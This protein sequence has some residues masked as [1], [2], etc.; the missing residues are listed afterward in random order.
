MNRKLL[1]VAAA[2][3][4]AAVLIVIIIVSAG[5]LRSS[6]P[7]KRGVDSPAGIVAAAQDAEAKGNIQ[8][9]RSRYQRLVSEF[10]NSKDVMNWQ[11]KAEDLNIK[12]LFSPLVTVKSILY[13]IKPGDTL[14]KIAKNFR[15]TPEL[16]MKSNGLTDDKILP[17][18]KIKVWTVPFNIVVDKSQ[19][20]LILKS[21]DEIVKSYIVSTG[22]NN[23]TPTGTFKVINKLANPTWFKAGAV[24]DPGSPENILGTR[25]LG[26]NVPGYGIHGTTDPQSLGKQATQ[27][28]VRMANPEVEELYVIVPEGT[29]V[30]IID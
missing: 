10:P 17:G 24:V 28:C 21:E 8:E 12:L 25:W 14:I 13:E 1:I 26:I 20:I 22:S 6:A 23:S 4:A 19:N 7:A 3:L 2:A 30:T 15:T 9:A 16:I 27:G 18:K 5:R 29:E 11:K